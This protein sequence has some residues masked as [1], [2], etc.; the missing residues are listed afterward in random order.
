MF[1]QTERIQLEKMLLKN[2]RGNNCLS[3][4]D[5]NSNVTFKISEQRNNE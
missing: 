3:A 4:H 5:T 2:S 1:M